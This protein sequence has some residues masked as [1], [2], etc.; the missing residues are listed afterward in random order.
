MACSV[1]VNGAH[2]PRHVVVACP[3]SGSNKA[4][5][6][7]IMPSWL[8]QTKRRVIPIAEINERNVKPSDYIPFWS[9]WFLTLVSLPIFDVEMHIAALDTMGYTIIPD[10]MP[11]A[12]LALGVLKLF[13]DDAAK[14]LQGSHFAG[15]C[16]LFHW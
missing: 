8:L 2:A 15:P 12:L 6:D 4:A 3:F 1:E 16:I 5:P 10:A 11:M 14:N 9:I 7:D 13:I